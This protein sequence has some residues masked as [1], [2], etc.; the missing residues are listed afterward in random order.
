MT[1]RLL[2][3]IFASVFSYY[4]IHKILILE[5]DFACVNEAGDCDRSVIIISILE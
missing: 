1:S 3:L 5:F 2:F 4:Q